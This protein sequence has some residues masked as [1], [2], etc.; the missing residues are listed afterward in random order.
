MQL[1][2]V[3]AGEVAAG[4]DCL[5]HEWM[6]R[7][8]GLT[9]QRGKPNRGPRPSSQRSKSLPQKSIPCVMVYVELQIREEIE[10]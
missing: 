3:V 1:V 10:I 7:R 2:D 8:R 5:D 4:F 6:P 9:V